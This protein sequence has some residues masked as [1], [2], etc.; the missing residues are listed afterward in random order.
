VVGAVV[1]KDMEADIDD[2]NLDDTDISLRDV[3]M[4]THQ[5]GPRG[6]AST[7][8]EKDSGLQSTAEAE[9]LDSLPKPVEEEEKANTGWGKRQGTANRL[10]KLNDFAGKASDVE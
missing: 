8:T 2:A 7:T 4:A 3:I 9:S 6:H 1:D 5:K 10:Y